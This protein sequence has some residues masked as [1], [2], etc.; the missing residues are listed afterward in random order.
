MPSILKNIKTTLVG[1]AKNPFDRT[2]FHKLSLIAFLAWIGLGADGLSSSCYG[3]ESAFLALQG[4][5][6]LSV[7][8]AIATVI[9]VFLISASYAQIIELFPSGGGGYLVASKLLNPSLG[10]VSGCAL[11]I[12]YVLTISL[13]IA[14]GADA[15]FSFLPASFLPFK[16][17]AGAIIL[18]VLIILNMRGVRETIEPLI[19]VFL[20]FLATHIFVILYAFITHAWQFPEIIS[21]ARNEAVNASA[22]I[23]FAGVMMMMMRSYSLGAGTYTG[24]EAVSNGL[25][26]LRAP[27]VETGKKTM[28]YMAVS[29]AFTVFGLMTAY[30]LFKV[31]PQS[32]KT[33]NAVL[34]ENISNGWGAWGNAFLITT[35]VSEALL[36]F[37]AAQTGF[38]GGPKVIANMSLDRWF[39][40]K[41]TNLSDRLVTQNGILIM[42]I[43]ALVTLLLANGKVQLLVIFY[44]INVF[45][46][47]FL[48]LLGMCRH[49]WNVRREDKTWVNKM[50]I[51]GSGLL[52]TT[53]I[54]V[55]VV[56]I[57]FNEGGW[58]TLFVT[59]ALVTVAILIKRHYLAVAKL[60]HRLNSL[61]HA[62]TITEKPDLKGIVPTFNPTGRVA[63][64]LVNGFNGMGLHS[65]FNV[66]RFFGKE[67]KN[68]IFVQVGLLDAG[69][70]KGAAEISNLEAQV[71]KDLS[72]YV[73]FMSSQGY[74]AEGMPFMGV[75]IVHESE[76][77]I[78]AVAKK[79]PNAVVF[80]GQ[81][82]F[83]EDNIW[84]RW[85]HNDTAFTLQRKFY[86]EGIPF[87][88]LPIRV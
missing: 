57:K 70:F 56:I 31:V 69:N 4:H 45:I 36:L 61:V 10:M 62:T 34:F 84:T 13:S 6:Y 79:Y 67:F 78:A 46:T 21:Q 49:W 76:K 85:L 37:V 55:S 18:I 65:L 42:G 20:V 3:P 82:V 30:L 59:G 58:L 17:E 2:I 80:G 39:P 73:E 28:L 33:L 48:S 27:Q 16:L 88:V 77:I 15:V 32:G 63:V 47:F 43:A 8:V 22:Q 29:L 5:T 64:I 71:K 51:S 81:L 38:L 41:F 40:N 1:Q 66:T 14:S 53:F 87:V 7:F 35:L 74:Y 25:S 12:D 24:I 83:P 54:L 72:R 52:L 26:I 44:S 68:F 50:I 75:D 11:L 23:G 19:P 60:L 9:T 86:Q